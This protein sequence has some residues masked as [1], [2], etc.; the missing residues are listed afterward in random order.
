MQENRRLPAR[1]ERQ[2][3]VQVLISA[4]GSSHPAQ[5]HPLLEVSPKTRIKSWQVSMMRRLE[6]HS[7]MLAALPCQQVLELQQAS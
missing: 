2:G 1:M 7:Q 5:P 6:T 4:G 3:V